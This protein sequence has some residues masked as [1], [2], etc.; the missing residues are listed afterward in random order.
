MGVVRSSP[1]RA[2]AAAAPM[3]RAA[4]VRA[5]RRGRSAGATAADRMAPYG[6]AKL[7]YPG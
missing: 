5:N 6:H 3:A 4:R 2:I 1:S 7:E